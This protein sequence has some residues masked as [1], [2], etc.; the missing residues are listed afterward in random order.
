MGKYTYKENQEESESWDMKL[1]RGGLIKPYQEWWKLCTTMNAYFKRCNPNMEFRQKSQVVERL[2]KDI[3]RK[4][5]ID[6]LIIQRFVLLRTQI[7][8]NYIAKQLKLKSSIRS[9]TKK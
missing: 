3:A 2:T 4:I 5:D 1:S 8:C 9:K 6:K 7:R